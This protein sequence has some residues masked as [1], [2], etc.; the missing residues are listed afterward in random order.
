MDPADV[1]QAIATLEAQ[2]RPLS[3]QNVHRLVGYGSVR[4]IVKY[5]KQLRPQHQ[6]DTA[7]PAVQD[8]PVPEPTPAPLPLTQQAE[9]RLKAAKEARNAALRARDYSRSDVM[10]DYQVRETE[11]EVRRAQAWV[12][13]TMRS[14]DTLR[15]AIPKAQR[16]LLVEESQLAALVETHRKAEARQTVLVR[17]ARADL[18][19]LRSD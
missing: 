8:P 7:M 2:G 19:R 6:K 14:R 16:T 10:L 9:R 12:D 13:Q 17:Q 18:E 3:I 11:S 4:D 1:A 15:M 5:R